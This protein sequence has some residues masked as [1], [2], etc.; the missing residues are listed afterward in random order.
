MK[1][2]SY[3]VRG[4]KQNG[5]FGVDKAD[6][7]LVESLFSKNAEDTHKLYDSLTAVRSAQCTFAEMK[8]KI[9]TRLNPPL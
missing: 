6:H 2:K 9:F 1:D 8:S 5:R 7:R 3:K 4:K